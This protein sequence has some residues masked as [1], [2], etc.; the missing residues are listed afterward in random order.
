MASDKSVKESETTALSNLSI[1]EAN[2]TVTLTAEQRRDA[3]QPP[4]GSIEEEIRVLAY[5][6]WE[7]SECPGGDGVEFWLEA[8]REINAAQRTS[9]AAKES[10]HSID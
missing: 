3:D 9:I 5:Y 2:R 10:A 6:K 4:S 1:Q 8:E 7:S